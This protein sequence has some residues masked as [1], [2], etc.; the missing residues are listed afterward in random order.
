MLG[1][2]VVTQ[3]L[4]YTFINNLSLMI[5][6]IWIH[7]QGSLTFNRC[8]PKDERIRISRFRPLAQFFPALQSSKPLLQQM[9]RAS[10]RDQRS[11]MYSIKWTLIVGLPAK[12]LSHV[13]PASF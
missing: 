6:S 5:I 11:K 12:R 2:S 8:L 3:S 7:L 1:N 4:N 13:I 9:Q 10:R